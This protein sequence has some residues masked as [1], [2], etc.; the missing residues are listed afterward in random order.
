MQSKLAWMKRFN[1]FN[2]QFWKQLF[3]KQETLYKTSYPKSSK[4]NFASFN[5]KN[6]KETLSK[7]NFSFVYLFLQQHILTSFTSI[8]CFQRQTVQMWFVVCKLLWD[9]LVCHFSFWEKTGLVSE[10]TQKLSC[11][12]RNLIC[13]NCSLERNTHNIWNK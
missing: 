8:S 6:E 5:E 3:E 10:S 11:L 7:P 4:D 13:Y 1:I 9:H 2:S 12:K